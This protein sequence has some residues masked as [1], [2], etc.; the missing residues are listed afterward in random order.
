MVREATLADV[1]DILRHGRD[2]FDYS[3]WAG[4]TQYD[5]VSTQQTVESLIT[6]SDGVVFISDAGILGGSIFPL[7][8]NH[9][10]RIAYEHFWFAPDG[11]GD[12]RQ[13][14]EGW[15][16]VRGA[17]AIQMSCLVDEREPAMRRLYRI[18]GYE[19]TETG[20]IKEIV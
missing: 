8:F 6:H 7:Y 15:A 13:A 1:P 19:P 2:F 16:K 10:Y 20:L 5:E 18:K 17:V 4:R 12:L 11:G 14:F 9:S 3:P